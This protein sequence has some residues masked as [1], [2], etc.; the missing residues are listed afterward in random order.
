MTRGK[1]VGSDRR[2]RAALE[3]EN[4]R[5][6]HF[7]RLFMT[8][9]ALIAQSDLDGRIVEFNDAWCTTLGFPREEFEGRYFSELVHPDDVES[10]L[11]EAQRLIDGDGVCRNFRNRCICSD[12]SYV[13]LRWLIYTDNVAGRHYCIAENISEEVRKEQLLEQTSRMAKIGGW[14]IDVVRARVRWSDAVYRM[15]AVALGE[16]VSLAQALDFYPPGAR[17]TIAAAIDRAMVMGAP[18]DLELPLINR[19]GERLWVRALGQ[20]ERGEGGRVVRIYGTVQDIT[21]AHLVEEARQRRDEHFRKVFDILPVATLLLPRDGEVRGNELFEA[22]IGWPASAF[23]SDAW[24]ELAIADPKMRASAAETWRIALEG[25][26]EGASEA[27]PE[28]ELKLEC[29]DGMSRIFALIVAGIADLKTVLFKEVGE[30]RRLIGELESQGLLLSELHRVSA[31][32]NLDLGAKIDRLLSL[33]VGVLGLESAIVTCCDGDDIIVENI[34]G[35]L[36]AAV[37]PGVRVPLAGTI[38]EELLVTGEVLVLEPLKDS[39]WAQGPWLELGLETMIGAPLRITEAPLGAL[40]FFCT[41]PRAPFSE[42]ERDVV[43]IFARWLAYELERRNAHRQLA[44]ALERAEA[45]SRAKST[46]LATMS[47]ELRTPMNGVVG[48]ADIL[49][50]DPDAAPVRERL[51]TIKTSALALLSVLNQILDLSKI[52]AGKLT[53]EETAFSPD[54]LIEEVVQLLS[55]QI[56]EAGLE[57]ETLSDWP[58]G[59]EA[60]GDPLRVRQIILNFVDNAV[61]FTPAGTISI[62][63]KHRRLGE[64]RVLLRIEVSDE[65]P[66]VREEDLQRIFEPFERLHSAGDTSRGTGLGLSISRELA[67]QMGG[68]VGCVSEPGAGSTFWVEIPLGERVGRAEDGCDG[69]DGDDRDDG[70]DGEEASEAGDGRLGRSDEDA[71][72]SLSTCRIL[73]AEDEP[74]NRLIAETMVQSLGCSIESVGDGRAAVER[75]RSEHYDAVLM[76]CRMPEMDGLKATAVIRQT[77]G[78]ARRVPIIAL[79]AN[80]MEGDRERCLAA[81]MDDF[82]P[83]PVTVEQ[84]ERVLRAH[85]RGGSSIAES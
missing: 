62:E 59:A 81:G 73:L 41:E 29:A 31:D 25:A 63:L 52:E 23:A 10:T 32:A 61:K 35:P 12:G 14:E 33:C 47:H 18:W 24:I 20:V 17:K 36:A 76:D 57:L 72:V 77:E 45:A 21:T 11:V 22:L 34:C 13:W 39:R 83:K 15:H 85:L 28:L 64:D 40:L 84:L 65:G 56:Q 7:Y 54:H 58:A 30:R 51:T 37:F 8:S 60:I 26:S 5:L 38:S 80:A 71:E 27:E 68:R 74:V 16:E 6:R 67:V 19:A 43:K 1:R 79:T 3:A 42:R 9:P 53:L 4:E 78:R 49:L 44:T 69:C 48:M 50:R 75:L 2:E 46:F 55:P 70:D 66:G 82:L